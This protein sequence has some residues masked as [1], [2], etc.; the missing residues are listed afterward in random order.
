MPCPAAI[1]STGHFVN[2]HAREVDLFPCCLWERILVDMPAVGHGMPQ[3][4]PN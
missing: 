4:C 3:A 1:P 2:S